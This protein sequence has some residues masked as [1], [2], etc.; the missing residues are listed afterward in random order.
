LDLDSDGDGIPDAIEDT[1][2]NGTVPCTPSDKDGD[3]IPNYKD[4]DSDGDGIPDSVEKGNGTTPQD[5]DGDGIPNYLDLDSDNDG[6]LDAYENQVCPTAVVLCDT[7]G[8]GIPNYIDLDSDGDGKSDVSEAKG[9]D[10]NNDGK[11]D[12]TINSDGVPSS[13]GGGLTPPDANNDGKTDPYDIAGTIDT[14][15]DGIPD[16]VEKGNGTTPQDTDGDGIPNYLDLDSDNDGILDAYENNVCV[17][18][19]VLCDIDSDGIPNYM[20]L[21]SDND[22][23]PDV[24]E[25][26][27]KDD[28]GDGKADGVSNSKGIPSSANNGNTPPNTDSLGYTDPYDLDSDNDGILDSVEK[29]SNGSKPRDTD[30]DGIPDYRDLD[31]DG[32]GIPDQEESQL[33]DCDKDGT[34]DY[35][36]PDNCDGELPNYISPNGDGA[37]DKFVIPSSILKKYPN[38]RLSIYNRWGNMVWRSNGVYQNNWG[39]EHYDASNLPDGVYYYIMELESIVEKNK[40][41]FIQVMRH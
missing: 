40:T 5:S 1:G 19:V 25:S 10:A 36:D 20:D 9:T 31:S 15:G 7:D 4:L 18:S 12:G 38:L 6:I 35:L 21:D 27:G 17:P 28:N 2:C 39:G 29:G 3:G 33:E 24:I 30:G 26:N 8:D 41:G 16:A 11:A 23:I 14:D 32:D 34:V 37:N 22:G 13:A